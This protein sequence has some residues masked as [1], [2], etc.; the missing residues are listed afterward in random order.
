MVAKVRSNDFAIFMRKIGYSVGLEHTRAR[1]RDFA[2]LYGSQDT[3]GVGDIKRLLHLPAPDGWNL[4]PQNE[5]ILDFLRSLSVVS[6]KGPEVSVLELGEALG[7]SWRL[8][9]G[10]GF[11]NALDFLLAHAIVIADG[12]VFL[13]ALACEFDEIQFAAAATRLIEFKWDILE[14]AFKTAQ[15]RAAIY[16]AVTIEAQESNPGSRGHVSPGGPLMGPDVRRGGPLGQDQGRPDIKISGHYLAKALGRRKAWAA[17]LGLCDTAGYTTSR[18]R[19]LLDGLAAAGY[20][21]PSCMATWPL[22]HEL[23]SPMFAGMS[24]PSIVPRLSSWDFLVLVGR[25]MGLLPIDGRAGMDTDLA[26]MVRIIRTYRSLNQTR[27]LVRNEVPV[28]VAFRCA[29]GL[30]IGS[31][32]V[33]DYPALL[34]D[35]QRQASPRVIARPSTVAEL[36]LSI[37]GGAR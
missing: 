2:R 25:S 12:D 23:A 1:L 13:N 24:F 17:S 14:Q 15:Q 35:E 22:T 11:E 10:D 7:I 8:Q 21:G 4:Q 19:Q 32:A 5:H 27:S 36:A 29:L 6:V 18:G 3:L 26:A 9:C 28:R 20:A 34:S 30:E 16:R 37:P 31:P 33:P